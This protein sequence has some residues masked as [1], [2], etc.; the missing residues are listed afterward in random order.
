[1][2]SS[3]MDPAQAQHLAMAMIPFIGLFAILIIAVLIIPL[4]IAYRK[5]GLPPAL[6]LLILVPGVGLLIALYVLAFA[7]WKVVP[8][9]E[10]GGY[11]PPPYPPPGYSPQTGYASPGS[12][13]P[14]GYAPPPVYPAGS[15]SA[16]P[17]GTPQSEAAPQGRPPLS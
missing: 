6:S 2:N 15:G 1:M 16:V 5:A 4:W 17:G 11:P 8:A 10:F 3:Q 9:P 14:A 7:R 12:Y 13:A